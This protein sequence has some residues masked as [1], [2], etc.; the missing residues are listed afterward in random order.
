MPA[1]FPT[2]GSRSPT[3]TGDS[4]G[5]L[6]ARGHAPRAADRDDTGR[7]QHAAQPRR[8]SRAALAQAGRVGVHAPRPGA[9]HRRRRARPQLRRRRRRGRPVVLPGRHPPL[10]PGAGG[11]LRVPAR[12]RRRRLLGGVDVPRQRLARAHPARCSGQ[13]LRRARGGARHAP[14]RRALHLPRARSARAGLEGCA[15]GPRT[16]GAPVQPSAVGRGADPR[17]RRHGADRRFGQLPRRL[18]DRRRARRGRAGRAARAALAPQCREWSTT[19]RA[20]GA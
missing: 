19:C 17:A 3:R 8:G 5:R 9:D 13:E 10:D 14:G 18:D 20:W 2:C 1:A 16:R 4:S 12:L 15:G 7:R 6:D 11:G